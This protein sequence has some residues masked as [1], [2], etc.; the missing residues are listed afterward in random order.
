MKFLKLFFILILFVSGETFADD[1]KK[2][3]SNSDDVKFSS[4]IIQVDE[5]NKIVTAMTPME[6]EPYLRYGEPER[7]KSSALYQNP[8][9]TA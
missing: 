9:A 7:R 5:K 4:D 8:A 1:N 3:S 6:L 2:L